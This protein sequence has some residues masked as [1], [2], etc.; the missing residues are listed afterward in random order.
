MRTVRLPSPFDDPR[1][2]AELATPTCCSCCCCL[3]TTLTASTMAGVY[4][5]ERARQEG[6]GGSSGGA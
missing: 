3:V 2:Q 1:R 6:A 4:A 5:Y